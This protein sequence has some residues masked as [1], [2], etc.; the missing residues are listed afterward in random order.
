MYS[1][2]KI[3]AQI[4]PLPKAQKPKLEAGTVILGGALVYLQNRPEITPVFQGILS[5]ET[6][7]ISCDQ[8]EEYKYILWNKF[9]PN[10]RSLRSWICNFEDESRVCSLHCERINNGQG[11]ILKLQRWFGQSPNPSTH[12]RKLLHCPRMIF[13][14]SRL[15]ALFCLWTSF[16]AVGALP[17]HS[18]ERRTGSGVGTSHTS[19]TKAPST[20]TKSGDEKVP[21][22]LW[23]NHEGQSDEHW[24]LVIDKVY[25]FHAIAPEEKPAKPGQLQFKSGLDPQAKLKPQQLAYRPEKAD[26][27]MNL[28]C[29]ATFKD[30]ADMTKVFGELVTK[31]DMSKP[32]DEVGGNCMDYVKMA[33]EFLQKGDYITSVPKIFTTYYNKNYDA[34]RKEVYLGGSSD[35]STEESE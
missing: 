3:E 4:W 16:F 31:I 25:G 30:Q 26:K 35:E 20:D 15:F 32:A 13:T 34:V 1:G 18:H 33:L 19:G 23:V 6:P 9:P 2:L 5:T 22:Q 28:D 12:H 17:A 11:S 10:R 7:A 8:Q 29:D 14:T 21:V 24:V 27:L